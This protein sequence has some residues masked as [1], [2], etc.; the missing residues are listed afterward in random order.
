M[1]LA[2]DT[3]ALISAIVEGPGR[4]PMRAAM[5]D[6]PIWSASAYALAEAVPT[7]DRVTDEP[8]VRRVLEDELRRL[9]DYVHIVPV[10]R[11]CLDDAAQLARER[12]MRMSDAIHLSAARRLPEPVFFATFDPVQIEIAHGLGLIPISTLVAPAAPR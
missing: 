1:T 7:I 11:R 8:Y 5:A 6:D 9:W 2:F 4:A 3:S 10:D 12:P